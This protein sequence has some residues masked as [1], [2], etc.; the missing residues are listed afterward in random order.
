MREDICEWDCFTANLQAVTDLGVRLASRDQRVFGLLG[1]KGSGTRSARSGLLELPRQ[2]PQRSR[3]L[4]LERADLVAKRISRYSEIVIDK[5]EIPE[6]SVASDLRLREVPGVDSLAY[7]PMAR[8][9][10]NADLTDLAAQPGV[11]SETIES[12]RRRSRRNM[13][14]Y[15]KELRAGAMAHCRAQ[16]GANHYRLLSLRLLQRRWA[17]EM[18]LLRVALR[19]TLHTAGWRQIDYRTADLMLSLLNSQ[20]SALQ[21]AFSTPGPASSRT[22]DVASMS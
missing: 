3:A 5:N 21:A 22:S 17:L 14:V 13:F 12:L 9:M 6:R 11:R 8:L 20:M 1:T 4:V 18:I 2:M 10:T 19:A 15:L 7:Q 16:C